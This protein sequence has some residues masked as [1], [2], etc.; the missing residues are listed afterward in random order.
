MSTASAPDS[1][2]DDE[3][4]VVMVVD[5]EERIPE[6]FAIW[7]GDDYEVRSATSGE[8]ALEKMDGDV[9]VVL[10]DR[11]MP[12]LSGDE[13]LERIRD[14]DYDCRVAMVTGVDPDFDIV[15]MEFDD[16]LTKPVGRDDLLSVVDRLLS[17]GEYDRVVTEYFAA[18]KKRAVLESQKP[19][20][21]LEESD[22]YDQ[23]LADLE[24]YERELDALLADL[25]PEEYETLFYE[26]L[27][28]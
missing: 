22:E 10:L 13:V 8:E 12:G 25:D 24:E 14:A 7:L 23:L 11:H 16:Y 28:E 27:D 1:S 6:A 4:P 15:E 5:D 2:T 17:L 21:A 26:L 18:S 9:D 19:R 20:S 3:E